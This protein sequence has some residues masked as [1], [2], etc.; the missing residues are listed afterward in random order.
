MLFVHAVDPAWRER[1]PAVVHVDGTARVQTV[2][3]ARQPLAGARCWTA[4]RRAPACR[5]W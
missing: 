4:S 2:D 3:R 1:I 5:W